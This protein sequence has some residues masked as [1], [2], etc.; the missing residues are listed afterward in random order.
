MFDRTVRLVIDGTLGTLI[1]L[2]HV[3]LAERRLRRSTLT[4]SSRRR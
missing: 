4:A 3:L 1:V 2:A